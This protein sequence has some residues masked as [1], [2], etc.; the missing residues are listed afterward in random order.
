MG[1]EA[2][3]LLISPGRITDT[4]SVG[5]EAAE[6]RYLGR[7]LR[8]RRGDRVELID[9]QGHLW[10]AVLSSRERLELEQARDQPLRTAPPRRP[11]IGLALAI[12]KRDADLVWRMATEMGADILQPLLAR[13]GVVRERWPMERWNLIVREAVEQCERLW[14]P[15]LRPPVRALEWLS[16]PPRGVGLLATTR[17]K[18]LPSPW[19]IVTGRRVGR[20]RCQ[21]GGHDG[22]EEPP[23]D[24]PPEQVTLGIG[25]EG[26]WTLEEEAAATAAGWRRV[27][28][29]EEI[30]RSSTA[31]VAG[32]A[33]LV[34]WRA[35]SP[36]SSPWP[37]P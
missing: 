20:P 37:C 26:G 5:L 27:Q 19:E 1:R 31:A 15:E 8:L 34:A 2:R 25:P 4:G 9:G 3:R 17:R 11:L 28:L 24:A 12:P 13:R 22:W 14:L 30:L 29:G 18:G 6:A 32:L 35:L 21:T 36:P 16:E 10:S 7:V 23:A 33:Q